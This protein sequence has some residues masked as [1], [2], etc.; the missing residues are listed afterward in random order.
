MKTVVFCDF[1]GTIACRDVGYSLF[2]H[3]S[4]G[5]NDELIPD[6]KS[7]RL[8][9]RDC[10][11][12]EAAMVRATEAEIADFV[13]TMEIDTGFPSFAQKCQKQEIP[14]LILSDGLDLYIKLI[15]ERDGLGH[16]P[17]K[18]NHARIEDRKMIIEFPYNSKSCQRCGNCKAERIREYR[19]DRADPI[20]AV[21][22][23]DGYSDA[24][25]TNVA[26]LIFAKKDLE[27]Y[28]LEKN[29]DYLP[30][31][32]F[33]DVDREFS[34]RGIYVESASGR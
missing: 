6:W 26:D 10:L 20:R 8:S 31:A 18:S 15:L 32:D 22:V 9:S 2:H 33:H 13:S 24:C 3:F 7:G 14:L 4:D 30:Y 29:I 1:D 12:K 21:F 11:L 28:C 16:I 5:R 23:G 17:A 19:F 34:K 27:K 25:A